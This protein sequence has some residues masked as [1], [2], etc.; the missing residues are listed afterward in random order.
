ML[1]NMLAALLINLPYIDSFRNAII[2]NSDKN[3]KKRKQ[4]N[5]KQEN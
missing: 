2:R 4:E 1:L 5:K 3:I